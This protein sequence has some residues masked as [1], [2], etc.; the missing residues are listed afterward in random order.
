MLFDTAIVQMLEF[1]IG[2]IFVMFGLYVF[3]KTVGISRGANCTPLLAELL[4]H[5]HEEDIIQRLLKQRKE[6][7]TILKY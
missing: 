5:S 2:N 3:Q 4:L 1:L 6:A 7:I